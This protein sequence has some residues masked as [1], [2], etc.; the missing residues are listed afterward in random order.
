MEEILNSC[1]RKCYQIHFWW[2]MYWWFI[3][4]ENRILKDL[5][6][7]ISTMGIFVGADHC[8]M[9][10]Q[11]ILTLKERMI[12]TSNS[13][14]SV[15]LTLQ[16]SNIDI[17]SIFYPT[18]TFHR[19]YQINSKYLKLNTGIIWFSLPIP[20]KKFI[21]QV[22]LIKLEIAKFLV[23]FLKNSQILKFETS[24]G[25]SYSKIDPWFPIRY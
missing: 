20:C 21:P 6:K 24:Y 11:G 5:A 3:C 4:G 12:K 14:K 1:F 9:F 15:A 19:N 8:Q 16:L 10:S 7:L 17:S 13:S 25:S 2:K 22:N 23:E 18:F